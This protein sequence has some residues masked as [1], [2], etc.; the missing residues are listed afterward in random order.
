[1]D[2]AKYLSHPR[3]GEAKTIDNRVRLEPWPQA[4]LAAVPFTA[5]I[6]AEGWSCEPDSVPGSFVVRGCV[7]GWNVSPGITLQ[8]SSRQIPVRAR[9]YAADGRLDRTW[10]DILTCPAEVTPA[11]PTTFGRLKSIYRD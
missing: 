8:A 10:S 9:F 7:H 4:G 1:L 2:R 5:S 11:L 6:A 3:A